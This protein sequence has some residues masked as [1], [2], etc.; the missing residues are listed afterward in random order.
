MT[1]NIKSLFIGIL[2]MISLSVYGYD[3]EY[4]GIYYKIID[5]EMHE[6]AV[7]KN[8]N[9]SQSFYVKGSVEIPQSI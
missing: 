2:I 6:V 5:E 9:G 4:D 1:T 3:F 7:S 8:E